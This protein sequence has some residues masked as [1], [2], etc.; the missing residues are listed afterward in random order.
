M[1]YLTNDEVC[2]LGILQEINRTICHPIGV[3]LAVIQPSGDLVFLDF[4]D[5]P[6]GMIYDNDTMKLEK[7][8]RF[9]LEWD[10]KAEARRKEFGWVVQ[11][12]PGP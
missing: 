10:K 1:K 8:A 7:R 5:D 6:E 2:N 11:P 3:A 4:R 9:L 12:P